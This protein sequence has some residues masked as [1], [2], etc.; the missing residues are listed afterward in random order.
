[1]GKVCNNCGKDV[2]NEKILKGG[3]TFCC[4]V[5]SDEFSK[6][7]KAKKPAICEFC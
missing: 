1:M 2:G 7:G 4:K 5:C 6:T 3:S